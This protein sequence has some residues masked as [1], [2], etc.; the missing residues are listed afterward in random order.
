MP[1]YL[2]YDAEVSEFYSYNFSYG[3]SCRTI[4]GK[5]L[6]RIYAECADLNGLDMMVGK[7]VKE[8]NEMWIEVATLVV[9]NII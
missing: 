1:N 9:M 7:I 6:R 4:E 2:V 8:G 5:K 3:K